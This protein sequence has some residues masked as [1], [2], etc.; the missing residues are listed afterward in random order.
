MMLMK[1]TIMYCGANKASIMY[2]ANI[3]LC[4][5]VL[6]NPGVMWYGANEA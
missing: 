3:V 4:G 6:M 2:S 1:H 5:L